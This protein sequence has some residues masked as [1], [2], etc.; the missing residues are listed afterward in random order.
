M[1]TTQDNNDGDRLADDL[2]WGVEGKDGIAAFLGVKV[3]KARYLIDKGKVPV[4]RHGHRTITASRSQLRRVF[5]G[6]A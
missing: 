1:L 2:L 4:Q 6:A 3:R 5:T